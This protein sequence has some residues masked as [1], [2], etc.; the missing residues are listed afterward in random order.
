[1]IRQ[2]CFLPFKRSVGNYTGCYLTEYTFIYCKMWNNFN[3]ELCYKGKIGI[4]FA[5]DNE[6]GKARSTN[7]HHET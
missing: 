6:P 1:M 7:F 4:K 5:A 2:C 3:K